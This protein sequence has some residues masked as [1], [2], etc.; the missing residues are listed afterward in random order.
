MFPN[1]I[2]HPWLFRKTPRNFWA[3]RANHRLYFDW[4]QQELGWGDDRARW[5]GASTATV[6]PFSAMG[7]LWRFYNNSLILAVTSI[8]SDHA[9]DIFAFKN[10]PKGIWHN[11]AMQRLAFDSMGK[12]MHYI[13]LDMWYGASI[14]DLKTHKCWGIVRGRYRYS[15]SAALAAVYPSHAWEPFKFENFV[16]P[17]L[18]ES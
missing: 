1:R 9:W 15:L 14:D 2:W 12:K 10:V 17:K 16:T 7:P 8:Y 18:S 5:Y 4:I 11:L 13:A 3:D 6:R